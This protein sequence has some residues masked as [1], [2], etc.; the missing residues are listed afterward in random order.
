MPT[1]A[2]YLIVVMVWATTPLGIKWSGEALPP[3]AAAGVRMAIAAA[4]G[5]L[6]LAWRRQ[7]LPLHGRAW[8][9]YLA[10][11]PGIFGAMACSYM[12]ATHLPSGLI[13]VIFGLAP[14]LSGLMLQALPGSVRLNGWHWSACLLG[15]GG[16][17]LVFDDS[18]VRLFDGSRPGER[19]AG[20]LWVLAAVSLF[21][22]SGIAVQR[23]A[24]GLQPMQ[25]TVGGLLLSLPCYGLAMWVAGQDFSYSGNARGLAAIIYLAL[26]GS[27]LGFYCYFQILAR[28]PAATVALVTLITPVLALSLGSAL[29]GESLGITVLVGA[30]LIVLA[31]GL[32]LLGDHR[33]RRALA[34][35]PGHS[36]TESA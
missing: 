26:F 19:G 34:A 13:S 21:A 31:L 17:M 9:S 29:N 28:L 36:G 3:L 10:A 16:L 1:L 12:G 8:L 6:W 22:G 15:L 30:L 7:A 2:A 24:A 14:L 32:F 25:Q 4:L 27:L 5:L 18:L 11:L 35:V 33:V 23:V 20:L